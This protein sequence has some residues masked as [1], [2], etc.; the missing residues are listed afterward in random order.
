[1]GQTA[2]SIT[3]QIQILKY[4]GMALMKNINPENE[5]IYTFKVESFIK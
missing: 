4:R 2:T 5:F 3:E 1:M